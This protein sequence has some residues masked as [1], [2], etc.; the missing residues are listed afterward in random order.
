V[1]PGMELSERSTTTCSPPVPAHDGREIGL[2]ERALPS[3]ARRCPTLCLASEVA[4]LVSAAVRSMIAV[5]VGLRLTS[6]AVGVPRR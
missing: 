2:L 4:R 1:I 3:L 6:A 5:A